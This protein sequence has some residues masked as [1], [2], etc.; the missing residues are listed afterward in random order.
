M[1]QVKRTVEQI[2]GSD[3]ELNRLAL[4][5]LEVHP[6]ADIMQEDGCLYMAQMSLA[7][8][9]YALPAELGEIQ[10][11]RDEQGKLVFML[12]YAYHQRVMDSQGGGMWWPT[13][14]EMTSAERIQHK[15]L[16]DDVGYI[17]GLIRAKDMQWLTSLG[18]AAAEVIDNAKYIGTAVVTADEIANKKPPIAR[19]WASVGLRRA[20]KDAMSRAFGTSIQAFVIEVA[21]PVQSAPVS[22]PVPVQQA[23]K[24]PAWS[25]MTSADID[26]M[27]S[28]R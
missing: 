6:Q 18:I 15:V 5:I 22:L 21:P 17:C 8:G 12:G 19:T 20:G 25:P 23:D 14:R 3:N 11:W 27:F 24:A 4:R 9:A 13:P 10:V 28:Y 16:G 26:D 2:Y 1:N 7:T